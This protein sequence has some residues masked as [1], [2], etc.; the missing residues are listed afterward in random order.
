MKQNEILHL[1]P[2]LEVGG[3]EAMLYKLLV[4]SAF[5]NCNHTVVTMKAEG[6]FY[7]LLIDHGVKIYSLKMKKHNL[8]FSVFKYIKIVRKIKPSVLQ[9]W[10]YH[11]NLM[12]TLL[13]IFY[14]KTRVV[15]NIR[16]DL[17]NVK[18]LKFSKKIL[19]KLNAVSSYFASDVIYNSIVS[20]KH[21]E[22]FGFHASKSAYIPN[23]FDHNDFYPS[24]D[25]YCR[26]REKLG[27]SKNVMLVGMFA[28]FHRDKNHKAFLR[29]ASNLINNVTHEVYFVLAGKACDENNKELMRLI[30]KFN[31]VDKVLLLGEIKSHRYLAA[32]N[33][34]L[35]T[36]N[37]E[38]FPNV[39]GESMFCGVPCVVTNVGD[40]KK[41]VSKFGHVCDVNDIQALASACLSAMNMSKTTREHMIQYAREKYSLEKVVAQYEM[42]YN[43]AR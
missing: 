16:T 37:R 22:N 38:G 34:Y 24:K 5:K 12:A 14:Y 35:S 41:I 32:L 8:I 15:H 26:A 10:M 11:A 4:S 40:C 9:A 36:S 19:I 13:N 1:I 30:Q 18:K 6:Y 43:Q 31:L 39:I 29:V 27:L 23:G 28:R 2:S 33:V 20:Q 7:D 21:H 25:I 42:L 3:A 17:N